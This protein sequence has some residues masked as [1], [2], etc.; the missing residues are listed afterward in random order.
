ME[1]VRS[2][3]KHVRQTW[4]MVRCV[5]FVLCLTYISGTIAMVI[6]VFAE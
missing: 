6:I 5:G 3:E 2:K 1:A 4:E